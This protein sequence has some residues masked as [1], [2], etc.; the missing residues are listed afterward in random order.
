MSSVYVSCEGSFAPSKTAISK[1]FFQETLRAY[2]GG[3]LYVTVPKG[4][5]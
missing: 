4:S 2:Q 1:Q 3:I 5:S